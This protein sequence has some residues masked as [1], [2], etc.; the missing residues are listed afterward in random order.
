LAA[1]VRA[2][3]PDL[4]RAREERVLESGRGKDG[5]SEDGDIFGGGKYSVDVVA[6][7]APRDSTVP[8]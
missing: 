7:T 6:R 1:V 8:R 5:R 4:A 3:A 2:A